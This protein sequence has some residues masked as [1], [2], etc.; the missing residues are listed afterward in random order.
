MTAQ[1][2]TREQILKRLGVDPALL[3]ELCARWK[4]ERLSIFGSA[5]RNQMRPDS[6]V[7]LM[8]VFKPDSP[9]SLWDFVRLQRE[10][11]ALFGRDVD[12]ITRAALE[13]PYRRR[14]IERD[15]LLVYAA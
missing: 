6:D 4:V 14:T 13:N 2:E 5:A 11:K 1:L 12:L 7:D 3:D 15:L 9:W 8:V 10:L